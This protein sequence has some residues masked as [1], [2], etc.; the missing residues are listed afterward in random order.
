MQVEVEGQLMPW[1]A[2]RLSNT[3]LPPQV[4]PAFAVVT[5]NA[6]FFDMYEPT[7]TQLSV[8]A[9][10]TPSKFSPGSAGPIPAADAETAVPS[11]TATTELSVASNA[12]ATCRALFLILMASI[13]DFH[14]EE[15][16][17]LWSLGV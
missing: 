16:E 10:D 13:P 14:L 7:A 15:T 2:L 1:S 8:D 4:F 17:Q 12:T 3:V 5:T 9:Q 11:E 6:P